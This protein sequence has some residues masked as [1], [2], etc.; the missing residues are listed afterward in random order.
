MARAKIHHQFT[1]EFR[2]TLAV[3]KDAKIAIIYP[4]MYRDV[5]GVP[6]EWIP[7]GY[8]TIAQNQICWGDTVGFYAIDPAYRARLIANLREFSPKLPVSV[9]QSGV[10]REAEARKD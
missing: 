1:Q 2:R 5:G 10:Y 6:P 8:W 3:Q 4:G 7:V 9:V